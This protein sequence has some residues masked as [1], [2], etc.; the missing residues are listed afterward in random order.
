MPQIDRQE[1]KSEYCRLTKKYPLLQ[2]GVN[3]VDLKECSPKYSLYFKDAWKASK[4][5]VDLLKLLN[6]GSNLLYVTSV[7]PPPPPPNW[8]HCPISRHAKWLWQCR[9]RDWIIASTCTRTLNSTRVY[10]FC[11][12]STRDTLVHFC[13][14]FIHFKTCGV[15]MHGA[16]VHVD[17]ILAPPHHKMLE[18]S[19]TLQAWW[20][21]GSIPY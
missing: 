6:K 10:N 8:T 1:L 9:K 21:E 19:L 2:W 5:I 16:C 11:M 13:N 15:Y 18:P 14:F 20:D 7:V 12:K 3:F 4:I 17:A